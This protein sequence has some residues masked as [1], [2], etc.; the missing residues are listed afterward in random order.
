V[1]KYQ[2][3]EKGKSDDRKANYRVYLK[4]LSGKNIFVEIIRNFGN[5]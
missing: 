1:G 4:I 3:K 2:L 5:S